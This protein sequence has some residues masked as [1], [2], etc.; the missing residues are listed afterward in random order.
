[1]IVDQHH[2]Y[3]VVTH[4][5]VHWLRSPIPLMKHCSSRLLSERNDCFDQHPL[6]RFA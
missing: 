4:P 5:F 1:V 2:A 6:S 3:A